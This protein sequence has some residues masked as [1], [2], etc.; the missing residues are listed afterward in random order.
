M[1]TDRN[2]MKDAFDIAM[3]R[4]RLLREQF[5]ITG[6]GVIELRDVH[7][8]L[9][10]AQGFANKITTVGD[11]YYAKMGAALVQPA[12]AAQP[13]KVNGMK[14]GSAGS[15]TAESKS[16]AGAT[17]VGTYISGSNVA[18]D[19][20]YPQ[21]VDETGDTGWSISYKTTW[22]AGVATNATI[23]DAVIVNDQAT[24]AAP[25]SAANVISRVT[26][27]DINKGASDSLAITWKHTFN[28]A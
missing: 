25:G 9:I 5:G 19:S 26:F 12:N 6:W 2:R 13:T 17:L 27:T 7:G 23:D 8:H 15:G 28:A 24:N 14:L 21:F 18:F 22:A 10:D 11:E 16:G 1:S 4:A 3:D 20:T